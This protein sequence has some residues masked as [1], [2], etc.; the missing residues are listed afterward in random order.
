[1]LDEAGGADVDSSAMVLRYR[2]V[3]VVAIQAVEILIHAL[4]IE[5]T[6]EKEF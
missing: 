1:M 4:L 3:Q 6:R 5:V 2:V